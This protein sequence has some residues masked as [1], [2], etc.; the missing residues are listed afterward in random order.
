MERSALSNGS[1]VERSV[2]SD[3]AEGR[4][5][6]Q[7]RFDT[8]ALIADFVA[9]CKRRRISRFRAC[10][11]IGVAPTSMSKMVSGK[12]NDVTVHTLARLMTAMNKT[13]I[14]KYIIEED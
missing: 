7:I 12:I 11:R 10:I 3:S 2:R 8:E 6:R 4:H 1:G 14:S 9:D 5:Q 13:D